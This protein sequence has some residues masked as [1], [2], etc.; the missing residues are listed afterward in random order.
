MWPIKTGQRIDHLEASPSGTGK[1]VCV[2]LE[3]QQPREDAAEVCVFVDLPRS[4]AGA[5]H[6]EGQRE[7]KSVAP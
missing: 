2:G 5:E 7:D 6:F 3:I 1:C 4:R